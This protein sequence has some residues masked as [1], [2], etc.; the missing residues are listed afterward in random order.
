MSVP[1]KQWRVLQD[2]L[3]RVEKE[4]KE[5]EVEAKERVSKDGMRSGARRRREEWRG[6]NKP[7]LE[8]GRKR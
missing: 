3:L 6:W 8:D 2:V 4:T 1:G 7:L 5:G